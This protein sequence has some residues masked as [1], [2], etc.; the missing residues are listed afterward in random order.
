MKK[1][2]GD[3]N[4]SAKT[5]PAKIKRRGK[6]FSALHSRRRPIGCWCGTTPTSRQQKKRQSSCRYKF[7]RKTLQV[8]WKLCTE[9]EEKGGLWRRL[10]VSFFLSFSHTPLFV[11]VFPRFIF[12][13]I[14][15]ENSR[16]LH[17]AVRRMYSLQY[18]AVRIALRCVALDWIMHCHSSVRR[19][20][21]KGQIYRSFSTLT[22]RL[23]H[24]SAAKC[25][26]FLPRL[27]VR[28]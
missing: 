21:T 27:L 11:V 26:S 28:A 10:T 5:T 4:Q 16:L 23:L 15:K 2:G 20:V 9:R 13:R 1:K 8:K 12:K 25:S 14:Q 24:S 18:S 6:P 22:G 3:G 19:K 17:A 7:P